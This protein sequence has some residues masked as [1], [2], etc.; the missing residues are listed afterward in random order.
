[1]FKELIDRLRNPDNCNV[2]D[3]VDEAADAIETLTAQLSASEA[4]R[5]DLARRLTLAQQKLAR[6]KESE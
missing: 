3:D 1:M 4:A 2:L 6:E 5:T